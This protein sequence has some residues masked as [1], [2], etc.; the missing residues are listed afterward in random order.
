M[1]L[2]SI[3]IRRLPG[4]EH[5]FV[6]ND[7]SEELNLIS[8]PN[9]S[10]KSSLCRAIRAILW[11]GGG[12]PRPADV[13]TS[14]SD[15]GAILHGEMG[16]AVTWQKDGIPV[17]APSLPPHHMA[18]CYTLA[19]AD[20]FDIKGS[21]EKDL[22]GMIRKQMQGGY[23]LE[24][25][26]EKRERSSRFG[27]SEAD[28]LAAARR[29]VNRIA[30]ARSRLADDEKRLAELEA[31]WDRAE[32]AKR[33]ITLVEAGIELAEVRREMVELKRAQDRF[34]AGLDWIDGELPERIGNH[35]DDL[36]REK[37]RLEE[38]RKIIAET[39]NLLERTPLLHGAVDDAEIESHVQR[40]DK[41][42]E[43]AREIASREE[44]AA[45]AGAVLERCG[46]LLAGSIPPERLEEEATELI[47]RT[48]RW[49]EKISGLRERRSAL[50]T[51]LKTLADDDSPAGDGT[52]RSAA[53]LDEAIRSLLDWIASPGDAPASGN[54][55]SATSIPAFLL[56]ALGIAGAFLLTPWLIVLAGAGVALL[57]APLFRRRRRDDGGRRRAARERFDRT[58]IEPPE[59]WNEAAVRERVASLLRE[60]GEI[61]ALK[62][63]ALLRSDEERKVRARLAGLEKEEAEAAEERG[64]ILGAAGMEDDRRST[65]LR[66]HYVARLVAD[67]C[68]AARKMTEA[69]SLLETARTAHAA[70]FEAVRRFVEHHL[71]EA[72]D[73]EAACDAAIGKI[74]KESAILIAASERR[75]MANREI[76]RLVEE[77]EEQN[78]SID[79]LYERAAIDPSDREEAAADLRAKLALLEDYR[80][81]AKH[82]GRVETKIADLT[83][84]LKERPR[85]IDAGAD[86]L[87]RLLAKERTEADGAKD[88][89][90]TIGRI[91]GEIEAATASADLEEAEAKAARAEEALREKGDDLLLAAAGRF[92]LRRA[93]DEYDRESRP[94]V[95]KQASARFSEFTGEKYELV[96]RSSGEQGGELRAV[97]SG[98]GRGLA[99]EELS[100]ATRAQLLLAARLSYAMTRETERKV[101]IFLDEA[102]STSDPERFRAVAKSV[103]ALCRGGRQVFYLTS[104]PVDCEAW[105]RIAADAGIAV[106]EVDLA[107]A[108]NLARATVPSEALVPPAAMEPP[109]PSGLSEEEYA[110][111]LGVPAPDR[112]APVGEMHIFFL[113]RE[114]LD[115]LYRLLRA[116]IGTIGQWEVMRR[117]GAAR[118]I[119][120]GE[121]EVFLEGRRAIAAAFARAWRAGRNRPLSRAE[122]A[123]SGVLSDR[124]I[125]AA[126]DILEECGGDAGRLLSILRL[127]SDGR[128]KGFQ[129]R[130]ADRLEE[131]LEENGF[132]DA[133]ATLDDGA[134]RAEVLGRI[135]ALPKEHRPPAEEVHRAVDGWLRLFAP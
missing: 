43:A 13:A 58:G 17:P 76:P 72:P 107:A 63:R 37:E 118:S 95:L 99:L 68:D 113:T 29:E 80:E 119:V 132:I 8:G 14:W 50:E 41:A 116:R 5:P 131:W 92:L 114:R 36:A 2:R 111:R 54:S 123:L 10:G 134:I 28:A 84:R 129:Q 1:K 115:L 12:L 88:L 57:A 66:V 20:L 82:K 19:L 96:F 40:L 52:D 26:L 110:A 100:D 53:T 74:R 64:A 24:A 70:E 38:K 42:K 106:K 7:L 90:E 87:E 127:K 125:G 9:G 55:F 69:K 126:T 105:K 89:G 32:E 94:E 71:G 91:K 79:L 62:E 6:L 75:D 117:R 22:S 83:D 65:D 73:D 101:P 47:D 122:L 120:T 109:D 112:F 33:E 81:T 97:E 56:L 135:A 49:I 18:R 98:S 78:R 108:R 61:Q 21:T 46:T 4:I 23:D 77:I 85:Y 67:W 31:S 130:M 30:D 34:P 86:D 35:L 124:W 103:I 48:D 51:A 104:D 44:K 3:E 93:G 102:L 27:K 25:L 16:S 11:P 45:A 39:D 60:V 128:M 121:E 15:N 59:R 133:A